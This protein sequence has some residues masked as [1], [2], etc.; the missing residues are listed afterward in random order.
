LLKAIARYGYACNE[1][2]WSFEPEQIFRDLVGLL[3]EIVEQ[4]A[5]V[6]YFPVY[7]EGAVDRHIRMRAEELN[8][9]AKQAR[10][11]ARLASQAVGKTQ[12]VRVVAPTAVETLD[13]LYRQLKK[14]R[15]RKMSSPKQEALL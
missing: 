4:H 9:R 5:D 13:A 3:R 14:P 2:G 1:R 15:R 12:V 10:T 6:K 11:V 7:L 8:A